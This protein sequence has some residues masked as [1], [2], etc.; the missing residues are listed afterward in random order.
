MSV[1]LAVGARTIAHRV[2]VVE[3]E[4]LVRLMMADEL[5]GR[6]FAVMEAANVDEALAILESSSRVDLI[7]TDVQVPGPHGW[8][9][10]GTNSCV[11]TVPS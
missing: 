11:R 5:R 2:L 8:L 10:V 9:G 4:V 7:L 3:D 6:G 1:V